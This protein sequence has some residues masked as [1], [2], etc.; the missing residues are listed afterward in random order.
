MTFQ[1]GEPTRVSCGLSL[2]S[3][4]LSSGGGPVRK[5]TDELIA[6]AQKLAEEVGDPRC[7]G[8]AHLAAG[9]AALLRGEYKQATSILLDAE[10]V[11]L[12]QC[13]GVMWERTTCQ[14]FLL[15]CFI[16]LGDLREV[17]RRLPRMVSDA[18]ERGNLLAATEARTRSNFGWLAQGQVDRAQHELEEALATWSHRGFHRQHYNA[19]ISQ[20]NIHLY[21]GHPQAAWELVEELWLPLEKSLLLRVQVLRSE[22]NFLRAR[23]A[24]AAAAA[25]GDRKTLL[26]I[27][28]RHAKALAKE[29]MPWVDPLA[30]L[31]RA[32]IM[33]Q[34][35]DQEMAKLLLQ[36]AVDRFERVDLRLYATAASRRL[37]ELTGQEEL[38]TQSSQVM[39]EQ[40]IPEPDRVTDVL[41]PG[42]RH[43]S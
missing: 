24:L 14:S 23:C 5:R 26:K 17:S 22:S 31:I 43:G 10:K 39:W 32:A 40:L 8:L 25:G 2:V 30:D 11:L 4:F 35:G 12:E 27:A 29:Q 41:A 28:D 18:L 9:G 38:V 33:H 6:E 21:R 3:G 36:S 16:Y 34:R 20:A 1:A 15:S 19:L 42:F 13:T 37:G 7:I